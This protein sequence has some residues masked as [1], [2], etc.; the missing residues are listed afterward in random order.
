MNRSMDTQGS[1]HLLILLLL[2]FIIFII[3]LN[4]GSESIRLIEL[5]DNEINEP[6]CTGL[7]DVNIRA[8]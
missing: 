4:G 1:Y 7:S 2:L 5:K 6:A 8:E 3:L